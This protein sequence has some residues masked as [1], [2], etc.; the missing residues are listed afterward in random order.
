MG[1]TWGHT[2][3]A[4]SP[5]GYDPGCSWP[6]C[7]G[8]TVFRGRYYRLASS[9]TGRV[10]EARVNLCLEHAERWAEKHGLEE[11]LEAGLRQRLLAR[12]LFLH[13]AEEPEGRGWLAC[14][15]L[16]EE[17]RPP[18]AWGKTRTEAILALLWEVGRA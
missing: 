12:G 9:R 15:V 4:Y 5:T 18:Y 14:P 13:V 7:K 11:A 1:T 8:A 3:E 16:K 10:I 17:R 2:L 6:L